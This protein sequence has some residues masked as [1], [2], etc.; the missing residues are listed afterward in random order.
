M[1]I[2]LKHFGHSDIDDI[3]STL[4][5]LKEDTPNIV[6]FIMTLATALSPW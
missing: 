1:K 4:T 6:L 5:V 2:K 3:S